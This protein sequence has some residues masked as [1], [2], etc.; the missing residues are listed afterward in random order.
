MTIP[1]CAAPEGAIKGI[2]WIIIGAVIF[3]VVAFITSPFEIA[4]RQPVDFFTTSA[5]KEK[6]K[7]ELRFRA[8]FNEYQV[9]YFNRM[10]EEFEKLHP[11]VDIVIERVTG[12]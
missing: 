6:P 9:A 4:G 10:A 11:G 3:A 12:G 8:M 1:G 2:N 7:S 5:L